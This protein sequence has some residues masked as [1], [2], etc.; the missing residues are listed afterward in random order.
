MLRFLNLVS[1]YG[2]FV[3]SLR[4]ILIRLRGFRSFRG[5]FV[6][7]SLICAGVRVGGLGGCLGLVFGVGLLCF[8]CCLLWNCLSGKIRS[9]C[10]P[11]IL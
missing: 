6:S 11:I 3:L 5:G 1:S 8:G 9:I 7:W 10:C 4:L 2:Y